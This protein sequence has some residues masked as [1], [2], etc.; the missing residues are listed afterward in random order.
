MSETPATAATQRHR[1]P[2]R[3]LVAASIGNAV[4]WYDWTI[5]AT[6]SIYFATQI[7]P[8]ENAALALISTLATYALAFFFRPLGGMLLGRFADLHGRRT[9]MLVTILMMAGGSVVIGLLPTF[10]MV[11]WLAPV[12]LLLARIAQGM[13]LGGE[14]SNASAYLAE[15]APA[16]RRGRYSSF[17]YIS[18]GTAVLIASLMGF[19]LAATLTEDQLASWGWR[20]PF[21]IGGL[22]GLIGMWMRRQMSETEQ[23]EDNKE[24]AAKIRNPLLLTLREHPRAVAQLVGFTL[25]STLCYYTFFSALTPFATT[26]R[27]ADATEVFLALSIAT[28]IFVLLQYPMGAASDRYGRRPQLLIWSA[29]TAILVVP[30]S[31]LIGPGFWNMLVVFTVGLGLYT[32]MTSI[33]PAVMS[34]LFPTSVRALGIGAWY[35]L[36]VAVFGGT[37]P[38]VVQSLQQAGLATLFFVYVA[39]GAAIAFGAILT[40]PETRGSV[41]R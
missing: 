7:F 22:L 13:S 23:F 35:N 19:V 30:L 39:V 18:T 21:L 34:E 32:M 12:L 2:V 11:G 4:E 15:I 36:T 1:L 37:A 17:F 27:G 26:S 6:F 10:A 24:A 25:L 40:L 33:A 28:T 38:L 9:A 16:E 5:Y 31:F 29:S 14:V 20:V 41:L 3:T 8:P